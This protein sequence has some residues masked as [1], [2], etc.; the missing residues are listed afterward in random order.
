L[1]KK[2]T[3]EVCQ[4]NGGDRNV[5]LT[6]TTGLVWIGGALDPQPLSLS[7]PTKIRGIT[8]FL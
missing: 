5:L 4:E 2:Q 7:A 6:R 1:L 8:A 3:A